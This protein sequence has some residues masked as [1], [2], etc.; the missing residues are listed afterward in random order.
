MGS[1]RVPLPWRHR[2]YRRTTAIAVLWLTIGV[3]LSGVAKGAEPSP[4]VGTW[5]GVVAGLP[6]RLVLNADGTGLSVDGPIRWRAEGNKLL[7]LEE[8]EATVYDL[9]L[10]QGKLILSGGDLPETLILTR[11][12]KAETQ[13]ASPALPATP[14]KMDASVTGKTPSGIGTTGRVPTPG[15]GPRHVLDR[16]GLSFAV[17]DKWFVTDKQAALLVASKTEPG[18]MIVRFLRKTG[19]DQLRQAYAEGMTDEDVRLMP[20]GPLQAVTLGTAKALAGEWAGLAQDGGR[21]KARAIG[22]PTPFGDAAVVIG[23][24]SE[25]QYP[26]MKARADALAASMAFA[27][28]LVSP[29]REFL[30]GQYWAY[31][32]HSTYA[33]SY[34]SEAKVALCADGTFRLNSETASSG[35][36]GT[37]GLYGGN[38]GRWT[39]DGDEMQ[40]VVTLSFGDGRQERVDYV[41]SMDPK[42][43]SGYGPAVS[44]GGKKYQKTGDGACA[45]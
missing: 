29:A 32:G 15:M 7:I 31:S 25:Q 22:L 5:T 10:R 44:F 41:T 40:G 43:R 6:L 28:P 39:A 17:P 23:V 21:L 19:P 2:F 26:A 30:A 20:V 36:A 27:K 33:G 45:P 34:S 35:S 14:G 3:V 16:W 38:G 4:V 12:G 1:E 13:P 24:T 18:L 9:S 8:G 42:D 11:E 37:A